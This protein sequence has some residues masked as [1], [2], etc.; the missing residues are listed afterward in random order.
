VENKT[1]E[2]LQ[3]IKMKCGIHGHAHWG[4]QYRVYSHHVQMVL[5]SIVWIE[6]R[7]EKYVL[8]EM[9]SEQ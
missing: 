7:M 8:L 2:G 3:I 9:I 6:Q 1:P 4:G 5:T